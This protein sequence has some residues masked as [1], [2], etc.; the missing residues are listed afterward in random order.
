MNMPY[1]EDFY[2]IISNI[3]Q[4]GLDVLFLLFSDHWIFV[5]PFVVGLAAFLVYEVIHLIL[6]QVYT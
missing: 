4:F 1:I 5:L 6:K 3:Y 2:E